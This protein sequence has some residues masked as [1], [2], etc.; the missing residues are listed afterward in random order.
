MD[1]SSHR[2]VTAGGKAI[3][4]QTFGPRFVCHCK[5]GRKAVDEVGIGPTGWH[6]V[7]KT[8]TQ[9]WVETGL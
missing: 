3:T 2:I 4:G 9:Q 7:E 8:H 1:Q 5:G 6:A